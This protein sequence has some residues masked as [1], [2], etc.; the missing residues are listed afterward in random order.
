MNIQVVG[1]RRF[2]VRAASM[3]Q[4]VESSTQ[5]TASYSL[6]E[7]EWYDD[8]P[9]DPLSSSKAISRSKTVDELSSRF[10]DSL[11]TFHRT[12]LDLYPHALAVQVLYRIHKDD[13]ELLSDPEERKEML[14]D[15]ERPDEVC[16]IDSVF[17]KL[18][19]VLCVRENML[20]LTVFL[21]RT[22]S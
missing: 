18:A 12:L 21:R 14:I 17:M 10:R 4:G 9:D 2:L 15:L 7:V 11:F 8:L 13:F 5:E 20:C 1:R 16:K 6:A 3:V 22:W 19:Q